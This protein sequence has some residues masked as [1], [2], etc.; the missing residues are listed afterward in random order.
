MT[1]KAEAIAFLRKSAMLRQA[2]RACRSV[3]AKPEPVSR[4][5]YEAQ[6]PETNELSSA[7]SLAA[8]LGM[9]ASCRPAGP[10]AR[11]SRACVARP[12]WKRL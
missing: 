5:P 7:L 11:T 4:R 1:P 10:K 6:G 3:H 9:C 12:R 2:H 8:L